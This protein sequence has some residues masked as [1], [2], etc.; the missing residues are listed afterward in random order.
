M[1]TEP[2]SLRRALRDLLA[3]PRLQIVPGVTNAFVA[4]QAERAGFRIVFTTGGGFANTLLGTPDVGLT[5][6]TETVTMTRYVTSAVGV[7]VL[8]DADTGYGNQL[9]VHRTVR[10]LEDAGVAGLVLEDQISPKRC[11]HFEGKRIVPLAEMVEKLVA[12]ARARRDPDLVLVARTDAIASEGFEA[13]LERARA[14]EAAGADVTYVEAPRTKEE[15]AA[16]PRAMEKPCLI[17]MVEG[18]LTPL[19]PASEIELM[20]YRIALYANFA[21]RVASHAVERGLSV[22]R[23]TGSSASLLDEMITWEERQATVDF[24]DWEAFDASI[25]EE[26][27]RILDPESAG[28]A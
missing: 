8:A 16:I 20:G 1:R 19:L 24:S 4:K 3:E 22:L 9:N 12:A 13:A 27:R 28:D 11:G 15:M 23:Q 18:G 25:T 5:T 10:E 21:L 17:D 14:Y 6:L 2:A 26:A 7:P